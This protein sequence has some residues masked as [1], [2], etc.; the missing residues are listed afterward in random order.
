MNED[1]V[2]DLN[3]IYFWGRWGIVVTLIEFQ[4]RNYDTAAA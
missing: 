1:H 4:R 2:P 3:D